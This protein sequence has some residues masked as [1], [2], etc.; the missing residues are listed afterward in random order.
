MQTAPAKLN[1]GLRIVGRR[2][3][4][5]H[6]LES[7]FWPISFSDEITIK[8]SEKPCVSCAWSPEA[9]FKSVSLLQN[10]KNLVGR[11]VLGGLGWKPKDGLSV[12]IEKKIPIGSG[13]GGFSS[14]V[15]TVLRYLFEQKEITREEAEEMAVRLGADVPFF[16]NPAASWVTGIGEIR[17]P[18]PISAELK[19]QLFFLLV[20][21]PFASSTP[22]LFKKFREED[23]PFSPSTPLDINANWD[24][25]A[26]NQFLKSAKND[27]ESLVSTESHPI[28][29][30]LEL[31]RLSKP[32]Y[33][34][35][36][37]TG[38]TCFGIY[39]NKSQRLEASKELQK[40]CRD[41][42]CRIVFA[43]T[44]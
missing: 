4:G 24:L 40:L 41:L 30:A 5:Y 38:S 44:Y 36:S 27:L 23:L 15:G 1:L 8:K 3:D 12:H 28:A 32:L 18:V 39:L 21:F 26:L 34:A 17:K 25:D 9:P 33:S 2:P 29:S 31:L 37:G 42:H 14:N 11:L 13:L 16:L 10:E 20:L 19:N 22:E 7:L 35:L 43:E 6:F